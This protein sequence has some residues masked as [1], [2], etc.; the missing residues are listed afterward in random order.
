MRNTI[1]LL[2]PALALFGAA[3]QP[4]HAAAPAPGQDPIEWCLLDGGEIVDQP[5]GIAIAA[6]CSE[7]GCII[8]A[9]DWTDCDYEP[10]YSRPGS[11][12]PSHVGPDRLAPPAQ[13]GTGGQAVAPLLLTR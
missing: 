2:A 12:V 3:S 1:L 6:C 7:D 9:A 11:Q 4:S 13:A 8:C 10:P 5:P